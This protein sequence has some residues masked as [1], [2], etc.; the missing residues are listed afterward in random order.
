MWATISLS[1]FCPAFVFSRVAQN[2]ILYISVKYR[3][4]LKSETLQLSITH[5]ER[6]YMIVHLTKPAN[7]K[8][9]DV[10]VWGPSADIVRSY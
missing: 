4:S 5:L 8:A 7:R 2:I 10:N 3:T 1:L 6:K 9:T